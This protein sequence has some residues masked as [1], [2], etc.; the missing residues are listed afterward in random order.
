MRRCVVPCGGD[1]GHQRVLGRG[2]AR[3][4]E[5]HVRALQARQ[6][7]FQP[8]G[9][10]DGGAELLEGQEMRVEPAPADDVAAGRR[11]HHLAAARQQ[12]P[13]QQD[14]G[15]D[16]RAELRIEIGGANAFGVDGERVAASRHSAEAPTERISSTS[17]SVSR[18]RGTFSSVTGCS[19]SKRR[20]D[21][22]QRGILVA[23]RR[24]RAGEP[25]TALDDVLDGRHVR[26][27]PNE[28]SIPATPDYATKSTDDEVAISRGD[29][30]PSLR[31]PELHGRARQPEMGAQ[32]FAFVSLAKQAALPQ[33]R[34]DLRDEEIEL[35]R[36]HRRHQVEAIG[37][38]GLEPILHDVGDL[39]RRSCDGEMSART[40]KLGEKLPERRLLL[41]DKRNDGFGSAAGRLVL[42]G[43]GK[44]GRRQ[45]LVQ[46]Q[47]RKIKSAKPL[48]QAIAADFGIGK[49][50]EFGGIALGLGLRGADDGAEPRQDQN[51]PGDHGPRPRPA[52]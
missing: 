17:V 35:V 16:P 36:Q 10:R 11:Q 19:V 34:N 49:F 46:R 44:I 48:R 13:R 23:G 31:L 50:V 18:M 29:V 22:R 41:G 32:R 30:A 2:D 43:V 5:E 3:L 7:Q 38:A 52:P 1:R 9:C 4:V 45:R 25:M 14:R 20:G 24:D 47:M 51:M 15:A 39:F 12:R 40:G 26:C 6:P 42:A 28:I 37:S 27:P 33:Q 21:D 8:R